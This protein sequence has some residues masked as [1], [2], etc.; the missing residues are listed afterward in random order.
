MSRQQRCKF[1][2][3]TDDRP[4]AIPMRYSGS[5]ALLPD[6]LGDDPVLALPGQ[7]AHFTTPCHWSAE[8]VCSAPA[9]IAGAY[10]ESCALI[11]E[12]LAEEMA[13]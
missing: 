1:C 4:C 2:G 9:C 5:G 8:N 10:V 6:S 7:V 3:C 11:D 12:L 13:A